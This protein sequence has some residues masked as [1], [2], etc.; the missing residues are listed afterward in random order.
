MSWTHPLDGVDIR[1]PQRPYV[2]QQQRKLL[3]VNFLVSSAEDVT[4]VTM[5]DYK[6]TVYTG[7]LASAG[8]W[9][10]V[11]IK[12]V[13]TDGKSPRTPLNSSRKRRHLS[14]DTMSYS[15]VFCPK[16][17]GKL[18]LI[19]LT[20]QRNF[21]F[22]QDDWYPAKVEVKSPEA[23]IY[24]FPI[25]H[26][27][28]DSKEHKFREGTALLVFNDTH[29]Q[30]ARVT[31]IRQ[32][33]EDYSWCVETGI[34]SCI[35]VESID[36]LP[37]DVRFSLTKK[38]EMDFT[39]GKG[40]AEL[41]LEAWAHWIEQWTDID[42]I[43]YLRVGNPSA[44]AEYVREHWK[45]D[46]F[47]GYQLLNGVNP[48]LIQ[49]CTKLPANLAH[50]VSEDM[51]LSNGQSLAEEMKKG[52]IFLCDYKILD[53]V[54]PNTIN[55]KNQYLMAPLVLLHHTDEKL[56][57]VAI[58]L[59]QTPAE[60]NPV[61]LP[62]DS[63]YDWLMAKM[64]VR[65]AE[66]HV[67]ELV[68][69]LLHTHLLAEVFA[70]SLLRNLPMVH[71][72]YKLLIPHTRY[73]LQINV[74]ARQLLIS[75]E[76]L[77]SKYT[78]S[79]ADGAMMILKKATS[80]IT[81]TSLC[82]CDDIKERGLEGLSHFYYRDD[83]LKLW[84]IIHGFVDKMLKYYYKTDED[85]QKDCELQGWISDIFEKGF[86]SQTATGIPQSFSTVGDLVKFVTMVIFNCSAQ[87]SAVNSG[88]YEY[89]GWMPNVPSTMQLPPTTRKGR[90]N[91]DRMLKT[92]PDV[93]TTVHSMAILWVLSKRSTDSVFLGQ[94][95]EEH[96]TEPTPCDF[97]KEFRGDLG[98]LSAEIKARNSSLEV[99]YTY[100][101]PEQIENSVSL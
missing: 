96:F 12:L 53:E 62:S 98:V 74:L 32:K 82:V 22:N 31:E 89:G 47:F 16:S 4:I 61:F 88:Q 51:V 59:K 13:G 94:Y 52:N 57:P 71:P 65:S 97:I 99:P 86:H 54:Q 33:R 69:H 27:I 48:M 10:Q 42:D 35:H 44:T 9:N 58:Q 73:T 25:Y 20:K 23:D 8:T 1:C 28:T 92:L 90:A 50:S 63:E 93:Q 78:A 75:K 76:G 26:W 64:F 24:K 81:Y 56:K 100:L 72:L 68:S 37:R 18:V 67:H 38:V 55:G 77:F 101:D 36:Q 66:F 39:A 87:H 95:P 80:A 15:T 2:H 6:V 14:K 49:R 41:E 60:D 84:D 40:L 70:M 29:A 21:L 79:G 91:K 7:N 34:P 46:A 30:H 19:E 43:T 45:E 17:I 83:G 5:V 85:V 11:S 3:Q